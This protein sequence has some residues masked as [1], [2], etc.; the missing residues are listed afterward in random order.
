MTVGRA[1]T[2]LRSRGHDKGATEHEASTRERYYFHNRGA[3]ADDPAFIAGKGQP[4]RTDCSIQSAESCGR[5]RIQLGGPLVPDAAPIVPAY[6][7]RSR[8]PDE[9]TVP[10]RRRVR[11]GRIEFQHDAIG[12]VSRESRRA[13]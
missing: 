11:A 1:S 4:H 6:L 12:N 3:S 2:G 7:S 5:R 10:G 9:P 13:W 8:A